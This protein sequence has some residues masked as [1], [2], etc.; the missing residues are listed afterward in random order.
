[1]HHRFLLLTT[2]G[3]LLPLILGC[4][5]ADGVGSSSG[6]T[7]EPPAPPD[8]LP[9]PQ[10]SSCSDSTL[11]WSTQCEV[12]GQV[13]YENPL[14][15]GVL[16]ELEPFTGPTYACCEGNPSQ[17]DADAA[18]VQR[19]E[20]QLCRLAED[21]YDDIAHENGWNCIAGCQFDYHGCLAGIP[22]QQFPHPPFGDDYPH[23]VTVSC[24]ATNVEPRHPDGTFEFIDS[25]ENFF[26]DDPE[27]CGLPPSLTGQDPLRVV[28]A[29]AAREDAG[30][31]AIAT[32]WYGEDQGKVGSTDVEAEL[33]YAVRSCEGAE[34][35]ALTRVHASIPAGAYGGITVQS[36]DLTLVATTIEPK[37]DPSGGFEFPAGSLHFVLGASV[38]DLPLAITRTNTSPVYGRVSHGADLFELTDLRLAYDESDFGAELRLDLVG[39][40]VNRAPR[41]AIRRLDTPIDCAAPVVFQAASVDPDDDPMQHY[42]WTPGGMFAAS[43]AEI[44]LPPGPHLIVLMSADHRGAHDATSLTYTRSC[45]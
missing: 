35:L 2:A 11:G 18:C 22:V 12:L 8:P 19:C 3:L 34:C 33:E 1:M 20:E 5:T 26:Y 9:V 29:N 30:T 45:A 6:D 32:W 16:L 41:A 37:L 14:E 23:E 38:G 40:H 13:S 17:A 27:L 31:Q 7:G 24:E 42:W 25:P 15:P 21:I 4:S 44:V 36:A 43:T 28:V 10:G 39:A